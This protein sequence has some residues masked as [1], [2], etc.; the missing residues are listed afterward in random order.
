M[1]HHKYITQTF[2]TEWIKLPKNK[3]YTKLHLVNF[4]QHSQVFAELCKEHK[5]GS[6]W[7]CHY[8]YTQSMQ[9][10]NSEVSES[11][12]KTFVEIE[13]NVYHSPPKQLK[14]QLTELER[15]L[16]MFENELEFQEDFGVELYSFEF[17]NNHIAFLK[18]KIESL[19]HKL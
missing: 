11:D 14:E 10:F 1:K 8:P 7:V 12:A 3:E 18:Q 19:K 9:I 16:K 2:K 6:K 17:M 4:E 13:L 5:L 15:S